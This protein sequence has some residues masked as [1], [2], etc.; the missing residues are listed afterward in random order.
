MTDPI[1][2]LRLSTAKVIWTPT[3]FVEIFNWQDADDTTEEVSNS[4]TGENKV[5]LWE[6]VLSEANI[7]PWL[8]QVSFQCSLSAGYITYQH[9]GRGFP[10]TKPSA[11]RRG[12][13]IAASVP[14]LS[15]DNVG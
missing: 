3:R 9:A 5:K 13:S 6:G 2:Q 10:T 7:L 12:S 4:Y 14:S 8:K 11:V 15:M 1:Y